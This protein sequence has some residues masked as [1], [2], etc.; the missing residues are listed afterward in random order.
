MSTRQSV[1][2]IVR[3]N[4]YLWA[5][6]WASSTSFNCFLFL[7]LQTWPALLSSCT[8]NIMSALLAT[9]EQT[10]EIITSRM[11][12][13][14]IVDKILLLSYGYIG[15]DGKVE[16]KLW[17]HGGGGVGVWS[18]HIT[19]PSLLSWL[20]WLFWMTARPSPW[21]AVTSRARLGT[22]VSPLSLLQSFT[23]L[24]EQENDKYISDDI[25]PHTQHSILVINKY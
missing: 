16:E 4:V 7:V 23:H 17:C 19:L 3:L 25:S 14:K 21:L 20:P 8:L 1:F 10:G 13:E 22:G 24:E 12:S 15:D 2:K 18:A 5:A 6:S 11:R 9:T